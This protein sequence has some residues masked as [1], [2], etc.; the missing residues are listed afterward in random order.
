MAA[1]PRKRAVAYRRVAD[2]LRQLIAAGEHAL[3][4]PLPTEFELAGQ[5]GVSR[6]TVRRAFLDLVAEGLVYRVAGRGTFIRPPE[7]HYRQSFDGVEDLL[8]LKLQ[9][10]LEIIT[11]IHP[12]GTPSDT[13][14]PWPEGQT[15][16][17]RLLRLH[18][19]VPFCRTEVRLPPAVGWVLRDHPDLSVPGRPT[20]QTVIGI[21]EAAGFEIQ[22]GTQTT[23]ATSAQPE[24]AALLGCSVGDPLLSIRRTFFNARGEPLEHSDSVFLPALYSHTLTLSRWGTGSPEDLEARPGG[25]SA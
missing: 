23:T 11:P 17:L 25:A 18:R 2:E 9:T 20:P 21:I 24:D 12:T 5:F 3:D 22:S 4:R 6:Q 13:G 10:H 7:M 15:Y 1:L 19:E 14:G 8:R 16:G